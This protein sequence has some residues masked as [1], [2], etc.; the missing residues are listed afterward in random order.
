MKKALKSLILTTCLV[1]GV[2]T[3]SFGIVG[4]DT[5]EAAST[6]KITKTAYQTTANL[7]MRKGAGTNYSRVLTI[8]KGKTIYA[9]EKKGTWY[10]VSYTY[11]SGSKSVTKTGWVSG[12]YIKKKSTTSTST[13]AST[14]STTKMKKTT[15]QTTAGLNLRSGAG[16]TYKSILTIPKG[17]TVTATEKKGTWYKV[18][19]T[20]KSSGKNV[21]KTG[22]VSGKY[23]KE[24]YKKTSTSASYYFTKKTTV[25][26][27]STP[28]TKKKAVYSIGINNGLR[29]TQKV[30]N[31]V[32]ETW[33][34]F[35]YNGKTLYVNSKD[36]N[37]YTR[38][39]ISKTT[40][41]AAKTTYIYESYGRGYKK[42]V[43]IPKGTKVTSTLSVGKWNRAKYDGKLGYVFSKDF[44]DITVENLTEE[45]LP[46]KTFL[47][48]TNLNV[49]KAADIESTK[50]TVIPKG[51]IVTPTHKVSNGWYKVTYSGKTGYVSGNYIQEVRTGDPL[52]SRKG[53]QFIDLRTKSKV[54]ASQIDKYIASYVSS[55]GKKSVLTGKGQ[56]FIDAGNKYGVNA[57]FLAAHAIHESAYG[58][59]NISLG[60]YNLFG[61]GAYDATPF[62]AAYRFKNVDQNI[63][64]IA[65]ELKASYLNAN[66][67]KHMGYHLGFSTKTMNNAR[68]NENSEGMNFYYASDPNWGKGIAAH[69]ERILPYDHTYYSSAKPNTTPFSAPARPSGSDK[70]PVDI[71]GVAKKSLALKDKKG[72]STVVKTIKKDTEFFLVEK[73]NDFWVKVLVDDEEYWT[74]DIDFVKYKDFVTIKNLGRVTTDVLNVRSKA[75]TVGNTP[76]ATLKRNQYVHIVLT[77]NSNP[78]MDSTKTW[79][80]VQ[81]ADGT[82][83][84]VSSQY[85][86]VELK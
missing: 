3:L 83:G 86:A 17:K 44:T 85:I 23:L 37:K 22:W 10:K 39:S 68:I 35:T 43:K 5:V 42:L 12:S 49:R 58:T 4:V 84:W 8:P 33:Y 51:K 13:K 69:M 74:N 28:D 18:S 45:A 34:R 76:I 57:L 62:I 65:Q 63:E 29:S 32:G 75:T 15:Y 21:T 80:K 36:V 78:T 79:Y 53:Y 31:S 19:Y 1:L 77:K 24:Y 56:A 55:T 71:L 41:T 9:T 27:R 11:K 47:I 14:T 61:F 54:K 26:L 52:T 81:L 66:N 25:Y 50:L 20:Y 48:N 2:S 6:V 30:V 67:W 59:S 7:N 46:K 72:S 16:T 40:L 70:F 38:K 64:Y 82:I 60:K 73:T